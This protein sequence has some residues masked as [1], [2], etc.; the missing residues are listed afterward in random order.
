MPELIVMCGVSHAGKSTY[1]QKLIQDNPLKHY[2]VVNSDEIR[3]QLHGSREQTSDESQVWRIFGQRKIEAFKQNRNIILDACHIT[4]QARWYARQTPV[5]YN[6]K[7]VV[8][9]TPLPEL[10][11]RCLAV[12]RMD[13]RIIESMIKEF[14]V[15]KVLLQQEGYTNVEFIL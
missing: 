13:F 14:N 8:L 3:E 10:K 11:R 5:G 9:S 7:I 2:F 12:K 4:S 6:I 1:V 15:S